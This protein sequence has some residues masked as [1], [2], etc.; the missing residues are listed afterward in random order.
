MIPFTKIIANVAIIF[1][2]GIILGFVPKTQPTNPLY[3]GW[4][5][6]SETQHN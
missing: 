3:V 4:V 6:R 5:E 2:I 1:E